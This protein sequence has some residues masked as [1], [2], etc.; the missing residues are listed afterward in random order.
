MNTTTTTNIGVQEKKVLIRLSK[1]H[2]HK[3]VNFINAAIRFFEKTNIDPADDIIS[4]KEEIAKLEKRLNQVVGFMRKHEQESLNPLLENLIIIQ[5]R[6]Q[7]IISNPAS[8]EDLDHLQESLKKDLKY[9]KDINE[10]HNK[11]HKVIIDN[12][13]VLIK[14]L[15][16]IKSRVE[17]VENKI[18]ALYNL[19][20]N[21]SI[22]GYSQEDID[23]YKNI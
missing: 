8:K 20:V 7:A 22:R 1:R 11:N 10:I 21:K 14:K 16:P 5:R 6:L 12:D 3:I 9:L 19:L 2:N 13:L 18:D 15:E 23:N 17:K 4:P